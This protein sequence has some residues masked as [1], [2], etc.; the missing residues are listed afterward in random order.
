MI[1]LR[2]LILHGKMKLIQLSYWSIK[3]VSLCSVDKLMIATTDN[4]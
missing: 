3:L 1:Q 4:H 2:V